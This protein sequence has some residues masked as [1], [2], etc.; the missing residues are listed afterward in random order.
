VL[1][2]DAGITR[3]GGFREMSL[4]KWTAAIDTWLAFATGGDIP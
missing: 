2:N 3:N 1:E 4:D